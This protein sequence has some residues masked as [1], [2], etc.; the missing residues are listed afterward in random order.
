MEPREAFFAGSGF[1]RVAMH[2]LIRATIPVD[3]GNAMVKGDMDATMA[4]VMGDV[5]PEAA[6]FAVADGQ[7]TI[8]MIVD[9]A[10][11]AELTRVVEPLWLAFEADVE[12]MPVL[13]QDDFGK[14]GPIIAGVVAKY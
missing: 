8:F 3:A 13:T 1:R 6:Y 14:A 4:K 10:E 7:R 5:R 11:A 9:I 2:F 12:A